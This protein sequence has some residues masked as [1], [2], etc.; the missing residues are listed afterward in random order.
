M[1]SSYHPNFMST[2][3]AE[4]AVMVAAAKS[5]QPYSP[6]A[7]RPPA[8]AAAE[9][10]LASAALRV[11]EAIESER[12]SGHYDV[13]DQWLATRGDPVVAPAEDANTPILGPLTSLQH[14]V[15]TYARQMRARGSHPEE[16]LVSVKSAVRSVAM[17]AIGLT[18]DRLVRDAAQWCIDAYFETES[19]LS[20]EG[21]ERS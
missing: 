4:A 7:N 20:D 13:V 14:A 21:E 12:A 2:A 5:F 10:E 19:P 1:S 15:A 11:R 9:R 6:S 18:L 8:D 3:F 17:P 16:V